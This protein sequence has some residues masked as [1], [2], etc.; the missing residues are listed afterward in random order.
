MFSIETSLMTM[1]SDCGSLASSCFQIDVESSSSPRCRNLYLG[2]EPVEVGNVAR[3]EIHAQ[4]TLM[5]CRFMKLRSILAPLTP[6][7]CWIQ[8]GFG[9]CPGL[10]DFCRIL[11][12]KGSVFL[13]EGVIR[14]VLLGVGIVVANPC[15]AR[16]V[17]GGGGLGVAI[18]WSARQAGLRRGLRLVVNQMQFGGPAR[19]S[20]PA[21]AVSGG[22]AAQ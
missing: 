5:K 4:V 11:H 22:G 8:P 12:P 16:V 18:E 17:R 2:S 7:R 9:S 14:L 3:E 1:Y 13:Q 15:L 20:E 10:G 6:Q 19:P 21:A